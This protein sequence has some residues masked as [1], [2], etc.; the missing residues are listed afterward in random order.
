MNRTLRAI[1]GPN[2]TEPRPQVHFG[3][4]GERR[5]LIFVHNATRPAF[6]PTTF[7]HALSVLM[8]LNACS[9]KPYTVA[10]IQDNTLFPSV[11]WAVHCGVCECTEL[12]TDVK[13]KVLM[14]RA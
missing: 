3:V 11:L 12:S 13:S 4:Q 7:I 6:F 10:L 9:C 1:Q 14:K 2:L 5:L 8:V